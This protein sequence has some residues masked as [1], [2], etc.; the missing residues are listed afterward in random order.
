[1]PSLEW[2]YAKQNKQ[3]GPVSAA[4]L[5]QLATRGELKPG[6]LVWCEKLENWTPA[7]KVGGLFDADAPAPSPKEVPPPKATDAPPKEIAPPKVADPP[8]T[9]AD[10]PPKAAEPPPKRAPAP[11][12]QAL[13]RGAA[14]LGERWEAAIESVPK[15]PAGHPFDLVLQSARTQLNIQF[16]EVAAKLFTRCGHYGLY[17]AMLV[18]L[19]FSLLLGV[20]ANEVNVILLGIAGVVILAALQY[21]AARYVEAMDRLNRSTPA[22]MCSAA[23][24]D[25]YALLH[26]FGGLVVLLGLAVLA[27][28]TGPLSL[29]LPAIGAF[30]LCQYV[31]VLALNPESLNLTITPEATAGE[32]ALGVLSFLVKLG[33]RL[34]PVA[35]GVGVAW[36]ALTLVYAVLLVFL[37]PE[38]PEKIAAFLGPDGAAALGASEA[39]SLSEPTVIFAE[40]RPVEEEG[41]TA[42]PAPPLDEDAIQMLPAQATASKAATMLIAFAALPFLAYVGFLVSYL[43]ID[44]LRAILAISGKVDR[45]IRE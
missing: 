11:F 12:G 26:L 36:G 29:V 27:V 1:M 39:P 6:D 42:S 10:A 2:Y 25:C 34:V 3:H 38:D 22:R 32:E 15:P 30:I 14:P 28:Q 9:A 16:V 18:L 37:P 20:K 13:R 24:L 40:E 7:K 44:V 35:F 31:A 4:E 33:L 17:F 5:K 19:V 43:T 41:P 8:P 45:M 23:F 21:T